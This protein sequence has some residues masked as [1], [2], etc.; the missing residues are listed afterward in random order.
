MKTKR[1]MVLGKIMVGKKDSARVGK[2]QSEYHVIRKMLV[3]AESGCTRTQMMYS[4]RLSWSQIMKYLNFIMDK[5]LVEK[6]GYV[7]GRK[8]EYEGYF[9]TSK[10]RTLL[11][12]LAKIEELLI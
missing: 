9:L 7:Q 3:E 8:T 6:G 1:K 11:D 2:Y 4:A 10:G 5:G 12:L